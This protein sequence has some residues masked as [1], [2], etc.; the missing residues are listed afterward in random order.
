MKAIQCLSTQLVNQIAAGEVIERPASVLKELLENALDAEA[1]EISVQLVHGGSDTIRVMDN[2][3]GIPK[4][5]LALALQ[6]H[7]TSKIS[8]LEDLEQITTL[9]FRGE[10]LPSIVSVSRFSLISN[11]DP[12]GN[13][14][15]SIAL[16]GGQST[17]GILPE[18][19]QRGT[20][21]EVKN[22]FFNVPAR[23]KF[24][25]TARTE[26]QHCEAILHKIA[27]S[28]FELALLVKHN[29]R[30]CLELLPAS[31]ERE[32]LDRVGQVC[33]RQFA[34]QSIYLENEVHELRI[35][36]WISLPTFSRSQADLQY[37][38]VNGRAIRDKVVSHAIKQAYQD[39]LYHGRFP[40]FVLFLE[41]DTAQVDVNAHP[42]KSEVR[43]R[44]A[45][46]V[47][48]FICHTITKTIAETMPKAEQQY[49]EVEDDSVRSVPASEMLPSGDFLDLAFA[50]SKAAHVQD[51]QHNY[52]RINPGGSTPSLEVP[53]TDAH[54][55]DQTL[56]LG[57]AIAQLHGI[58][59]LAQNEKGL[60]IVDMHAAHE[61]TIYEQLKALYEQGE[62]ARQ[63]LLV[64]LAIEVNRQ[65]AEL[66][67]QHKDLFSEF[68]FHIERFSD[69]S[70]VVRE[71]P[72]LL[73]QASVEELVKDVL[74]DL[75][76]FGFSGRLGQ[77]SNEL[78]STMACHGSVRA[79]RKLT[80]PEMN[81]LL[82]EMEVTERSAQCNH[83]R[84]TWIQLSVGQLDKLFKRGK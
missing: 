83:G 26:L 75:S 63:P 82:R 43:F 13:A 17:N 61:R 68:G 44:Q 74:A 35:T 59:I 4:D 2:G 77:A 14:G 67:E 10:A 45:K 58:Y 6:R 42:M 31:T 40:A 1:T 51:L 21:V 7:A 5:E 47:H 54:V 19:H 11:S 23:K 18:R 65:D 73:Q 37:F 24:L 33:G 62:L 55:A 69:T 38:Y 60:I 3:H 57:Y 41:M 12:D 56:P 25:R 39:V 70:I 71:V 78:L 46:Y 32:R 79:H 52:Q 66:A 84:P 34:E 48:D 76:T 30:T 80:I 9:G 50:H 53:Q 22:L 29:Q 36:G 81:A 28:R 20:T 49:R 8:S 16:E 27:L 15:W 64:P 72:S